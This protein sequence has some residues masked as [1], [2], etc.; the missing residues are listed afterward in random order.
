MLNF[1][2]YDTHTDDVETT[3]GTLCHEL[4]LDEHDLRQS[5]VASVETAHKVLFATVDLQNGIEE[6]FYATPRVS[7]CVGNSVPELVQ[8]KPFSLGS[9]QIVQGLVV[10]AKDVRTASYLMWDTINAAKAGTFDALLRAPGSVRAYIEEHSG[11]PMILD[12]EMQ[13]GTFLMPQS[14]APGESN[15]P[16]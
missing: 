5:L 2:N 15:I 9:G 4:E 1:V 8:L 10:N 13:D 7:L 16:F 3:Y 14:K 12:W 6:I 11:Y